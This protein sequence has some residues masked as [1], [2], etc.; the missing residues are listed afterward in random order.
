MFRLLPSSSSHCVVSTS[1]KRGT[2]NSLPLVS[3]NLSKSLPMSVPAPSAPRCPWSSSHC[4]SQVVS[5]W[6]S[7]WGGWLQD[8]PGVYE[9]GVSHLFPILDS[10][11]KNVSTMDPCQTDLNV[12]LLN[13][14]RD[15]G[16]K[17]EAEHFTFLL[18]ILHF[19]RIAATQTGGVSS[20]LG[21]WEST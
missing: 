18:N 6:L 1:E 20:F 8:L 9:C 11:M 5:R 21:F 14:L 3:L 10:V 4:S 16:D 12:G 7:L 19:C 15:S 2:N 13:N 17:Q